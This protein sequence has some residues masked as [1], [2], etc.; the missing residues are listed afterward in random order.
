MAQTKQRKTRSRRVFSD[1]FKQEAVQ[2]LLDGHS[3][4]SVQSERIGNPNS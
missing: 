1:K 2:M 3:A 4:P